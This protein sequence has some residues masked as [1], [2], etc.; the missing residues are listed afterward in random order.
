MLPT[1]WNLWPNRREL[2]RQC[3]GWGRGQYLSQHGQGR[4]FRAPNSQLGIWRRRD[5]RQQD[6]CCETLATEGWAGAQYPET[7][8]MWEF[9]PLVPMPTKILRSQMMENSKVPSGGHWVPLSRAF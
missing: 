1:E 6:L 9:R 5:P 8:G 4:I 2:G 7:V 3:W